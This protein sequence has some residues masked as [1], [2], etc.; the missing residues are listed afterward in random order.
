MKELYT[1]EKIKN[2]QK[3][4][5][6]ITKRERDKFEKMSAEE[7]YAVCQAQINSLSVCD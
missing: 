2:K 5:E 6:H 1:E 7:I 3:H 4:Y